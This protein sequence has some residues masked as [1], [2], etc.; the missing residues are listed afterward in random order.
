MKRLSISLL[1]IAVLVVATLQLSSAFFS[2]T[3]TSQ[4]NVLAAGAIDLKIDNTSYY[5]GQASPDTTW[6]LDD[7]DGKNHLFLNFNDIKPSDWGEDTIS[8]HVNDNEAWS[9]V[10]I[11]LT[12]NDDNTSTEPELEDGDLP[13]DTNNSFDGE[14]AQNVNFI[15]WVD[16]GDNV[17]ETNEYSNNLIASGSAQTILDGAHWTLADSAKNIVGGSVGEG[18]LS[19]QTYHIG[20]AWCFGALTPNPLAEGQGVNPTVNSGILCNGA[21]LNNITQTDKLTADFTFR[22]EQ[23]RNNPNFRCDGTTPTPPPVI[24]C[25]ENDIQYA[26]SFSSNDQGL[27]KDSTAVLANRSIPSA[28]FNAPQT[29]GLDSDPAPVAGSFFSLGFPLQGKTA[30]IVF[31]FA[32][33]FFNG[34]GPDLQVFEVTGGTYPDEKVKI[35]AG[36]SA[37]GPWTTLAASAIRDESVDLGILTSAQFVRLTDVSDINLFSGTGDS[38]PDGYDVDA[39]KTFCRAVQQ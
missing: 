36:P 17:L 12:S 21:N 35:E 13:E 25:T 7:L 18:L 30:S 10:D 32:Q 29:T 15:F 19:A 34:P 28:A 11:A 23:H 14:L 5:N 16:D 1:V 38:T 24:S 22:A 37:V 6:S 8:V 4:N 26:S 33:P 2:D 9:C 39:V 31:G 20:K 3:E 27:R